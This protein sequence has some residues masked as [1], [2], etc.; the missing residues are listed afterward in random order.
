MKWLSVYRCQRSRWF[1]YE[2][3]HH[4]GHHWINVSLGHPDYHAWWA[5]SLYVWFQ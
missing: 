5:F 1:G 4:D 2:R 3:Y